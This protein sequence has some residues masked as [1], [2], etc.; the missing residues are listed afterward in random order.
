MPEVDWHWKTSY[1]ALKIICWNRD[2][3]LS[4]KFSVSA[5]LV[6]Q[7]A[8]ESNCLYLPP[9]HVLQRHAT[10][11]F[12]VSVMRFKLRS[13]QLSCKHCAHWS[14]YH[15]DQKGG[16][17]IR[18]LIYDF[19]FH[20]VY[21]MDYNLECLHNSTGNFKFMEQANFLYLRILCLVVMAELVSSFGI[22]VG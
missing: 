12:S 11:A 18:W 3:E 9:A 17:I 8:S 13:S 10:V 19:L 5:R 20:S 16:I 2:S 22:N 7:Q 14:I 21:S 4:L 1:I 15:H 6:S